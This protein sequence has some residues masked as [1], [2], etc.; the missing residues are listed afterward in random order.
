M[1]S[2][3]YLAGKITGDPN[4]KEK[5]KQAEEALTKAG[6]NVLSPAILPSTGFDYDAYIRMSAALQAE[7][8][9]VCFLPDWVESDGAIGEYFKAKENKQDIIFLTASGAIA[10][11]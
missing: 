5:F 8:R 3:I 4:Y 9:A 6:Y 2:T 10:D 1:D 11:D 7:C